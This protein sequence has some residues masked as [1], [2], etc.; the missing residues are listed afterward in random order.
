MTTD[1]NGAGEAMWMGPPRVTRRQVRCACG[2][3]TTR[4][5]LGAV[6]AR[7]GTIR[8]GGTLAPQCKVCWC[9]A[10]IR[11]LDGHP[12]AAVWTR[13]RRMLARDGLP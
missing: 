11:K 6:L 3:L 8:L 9:D 13:Y 4:Y 12:R 10:T 7:P 2:R 1:A 5:I